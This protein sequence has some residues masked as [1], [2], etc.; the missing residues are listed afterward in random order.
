VH[1]GLQK[2]GGKMIRWL[3]ALVRL[4]PVHPDKQKRRLQ[5]EAP[6]CPINPWLADKA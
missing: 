6:R 4:L 2:Y 5:K 3:Q 1:A